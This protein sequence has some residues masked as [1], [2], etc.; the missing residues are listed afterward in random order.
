MGESRAA[1]VAGN[2]GELERQKDITGQAAQLL[3]YI[4][5]GASEATRQDL[6]Q[7]Q[8]LGHICLSTGL[9]E[10][11]SADKLTWYYVVIYLAFFSFFMLV[12]EAS[13]F[14]CSFYLC[15]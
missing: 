3:C 12:R 7:E 6:F 8:A 11:T 1:G 4:N 13:S 9:D 14:L 10:E 5:S 15:L 2:L